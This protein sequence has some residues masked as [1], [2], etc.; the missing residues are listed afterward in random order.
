MT[1]ETPSGWFMAWFYEHSKP[2]IAPQRLV[3][4]FVALEGQPDETAVLPNNVILP[5]KSDPEPRKII[6]LVALD[7]VVHCD[8]YGQVLKTWDDGET[9]VFGTLVL[10]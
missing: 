9:P 2:R 8:V 4:T 10:H 7:L 6:V 1:V 3:E 5:G